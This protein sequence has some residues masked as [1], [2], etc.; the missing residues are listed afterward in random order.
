MVRRFE[1]GTDLLEREPGRLEIAARVQ[2]S[3]VH[4]MAALGMATRAKGVNRQRAHLRRELAP[5]TS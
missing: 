1:I 2:F 3:L 5:Q 4:V